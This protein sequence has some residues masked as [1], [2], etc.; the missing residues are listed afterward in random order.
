V[1]SK[2]VTA[3]LSLLCAT[4]QVTEIYLLEFSALGKLLGMF[5]VTY[6]SLKSKVLLLNPK[7]F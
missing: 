5:I 1:A 3:F 6:Y 4:I 2:H 7:L